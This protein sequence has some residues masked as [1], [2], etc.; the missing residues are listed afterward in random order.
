MKAARSFLAICASLACATGTAQET[1]FVGKIDE[2]AYEA[3][4][5][6]IP[7]DELQVEC[8]ALTLSQ[9]DLFE[10]IDT[11]EELPSTS[12]YM[13]LT[14]TPCLIEDS[15]VFDGR[16][17]HFIWYPSGYLKIYHRDDEANARYFVCPEASGPW[18]EGVITV[19]EIRA[20]VCK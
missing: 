3:H 16:P 9:S 5:Q 20:L 11:Y 6:G 14:V 2:D 10:L 7:R 8:A 13:T 15:F 1:S 4:F 17:T 19:D 12:A 18:E